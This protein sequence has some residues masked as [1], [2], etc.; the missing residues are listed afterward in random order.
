MSMFGANPDELQALGGTL[1]R[2][3]AA[4]EEI[5]RSVDGPVNGIAWTGPARERFLDEWNGSFKTALGRLND[6]FEAA[7][8]DCINRA[9]GLR[10]VMGVG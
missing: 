9:D 8:A 10:A 3:I 7:G 1:R 6:A 4:V 2:Q 5:I